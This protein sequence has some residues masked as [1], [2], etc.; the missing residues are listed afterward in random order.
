MGAGNLVNA[1]A[2]TISTAW[3]L[4]ELKYDANSPA[5][6]GPYCDHFE[7]VGV[8]AGG[9]S[10]LTYRF[11]YDVAGADPFSGDGTC[12][13]TLLPDGVNTGGAAG[14]DACLAWSRA[15][16]VPGTLYL[17]AKVQAGTLTLTT[18]VGLCVVLRDTRGG[19]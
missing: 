6:S 1:N 12:S 8:A 3:T 13:V 4:I 7:I 19:P 17:W 2:E 5:G 9:A 16:R 18:L 10:T 14:L 11:T 15:G